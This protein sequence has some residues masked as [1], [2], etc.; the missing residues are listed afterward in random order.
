[1]QTLITYPVNKT[2]QSQQRLKGFQSCTV[3]LNETCRAKKKKNSKSIAQCRAVVSLTVVFPCFIYYVTVHFW[4]YFHVSRLPWG[5]ALISCAP[6][7]PRPSLP[8]SSWLAQACHLSVRVL[9]GGGG[10]TDQPRAGWADSGGLWH[11]KQGQACVIAILSL[12]QLEPLMRSTPIVTCHR[13]DITLN[14]LQL[15]TDKDLFLSLPH[16]IWRNI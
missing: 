3:P 11:P 9:S 5:L 12:Q 7:K 2:Q 4:V 6:I 8:S 10:T 13:A 15:P 16:C 1:M 14:L